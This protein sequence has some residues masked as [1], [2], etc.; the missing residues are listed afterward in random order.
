M[1]LTSDTLTT[2][3]SSVETTHVLTSPADLSPILVSAPDSS[4]TCTLI[5]SVDVPHYLSSDG[6]IQTFTL[7]DT[8]SGPQ[9][10]PGSSKP[11]LTFTAAVAI[12]GQR[13]VATDING[14]MVYADNL[15]AYKTIAGITTGAVVA[16]SLVSVLTFGEITDPSFNFDMSNTNIFLSVNGLFTQV[17][18]TSGA[19]VKIGH[20]VK[21]DT[22]FLDIEDYIERG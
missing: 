10:P 18:P 13:I 8:I 5:S 15:I 6:A 2:L 3:V 12:G 7:T 1:G 20:V 17:V 9:G 11:I 22:I 19:I 14:N 4:T 21:P 16:G